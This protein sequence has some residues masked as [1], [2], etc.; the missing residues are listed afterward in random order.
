MLNRSISIF[1]LLAMLG[2]N[3]SRIFVYAGFEL[4]RS[5][6]AKE[7]CENRNK[8]E[9]HCNG[10]CFLKKKLQAAEEKEKKQ[11]RENKRNHYQEVL[12]T[13]FSFAIELKKIRYKKIYP[14]TVTPSTIDRSFSIF[15]PPKLA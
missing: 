10:K 11:E 9:L 15:Q 5:Y 6:I 8:P 14:Q 3:F 4:N 1:L 2:A 7:L 13:A 12:P